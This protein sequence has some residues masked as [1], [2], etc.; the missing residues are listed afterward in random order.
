M[1]IETWPHWILHLPLLFVCFSHKKIPKEMSWE[2]V[3][4]LTIPGSILLILSHSQQIATLPSRAAVKN[5]FSN[6]NLFSISTFSLA[7]TSKYII[8]ILSSLTPLSSASESSGYILEDLAPR[9]T[10]DLRSVQLSPSLIRLTLTLHFYC[11]ILYKISLLLFYN[12]FT[13]LAARTQ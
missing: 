5:A 4:T 10:Y 12:L 13:G 3:N 7:E 8:Y 2:K 9:T 11:F 6:L 1:L